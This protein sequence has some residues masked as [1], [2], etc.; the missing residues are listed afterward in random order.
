VAQKTIIIIDD[1]APV[2]EVAADI[3]GECGYSVVVAAS[4]QEGIELLREHHRTVGVVLLDLKMPGLN[5][6]ETYRA[7]CQIQPDLKVIFT[8]GYS[9]STVATLVN[10]SERLAFLPKPY[11]ATALI[12]QI[13]QMLYF[14]NGSPEV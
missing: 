13:S 1:E 11:T 4:G 12:K 2:R 7:L 3:L 6:E 8:S 9:E 14:D 5:G 10:G